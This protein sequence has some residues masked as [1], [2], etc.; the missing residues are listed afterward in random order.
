VFFKGCGAELYQASSAVRY[1]LNMDPEKAFSKVLD[2]YAQNASFAKKKKLLRIVLN[3]VSF[4]TFM[5][6]I[7]FTVPA[8]LF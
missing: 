8:V 4:L 3:F 7:N 2:P 6:D 5:K 1:S